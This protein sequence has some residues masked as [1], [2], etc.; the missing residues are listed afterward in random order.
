MN[1]AILRKINENASGIDVGSEEIFVSVNE[2]EVKR[3]R[4]FTNDLIEVARYLK[5]NGVKTVALE[6]TGIYWVT[7]YELLE[8]NDLDVYLVNGAHV[9]NVPGR[10]SDVKDSQWIHELHTF[11]LLRSS[12]IPDKETSRVNL[13]RLVSFYPDMRR[14][15]CAIIQ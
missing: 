7:L 10:K 6:A 1:A 8:E 14:D 4:T 12:F 9:K 3:F 2:K 11:G 13:T 15:L 5:E